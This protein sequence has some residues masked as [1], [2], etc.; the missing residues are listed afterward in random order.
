MSVESK[1]LKNGT[2]VILTTIP[3]RSGRLDKAR[4]FADAVQRI[5]KDTGVPVI[6]YFGIGSSGSDC[7]AGRQ[8]SK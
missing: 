1:C 6:D 3:P 7:L 2:V 5:G 8:A 4:T